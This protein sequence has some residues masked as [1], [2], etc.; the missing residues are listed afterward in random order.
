[1]SSPVASSSTLEGSGTGLV[2]PPPPPVP[3]LLGATFDGGCIV[4][5]HCEAGDWLTH[6][7]ESGGIDGQVIVGQYIC[8][9]ASCGKILL[10]ERDHLARGPT[11]RQGRAGVGKR[12]PEDKQR[13]S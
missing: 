2:P 12:E 4:E 7:N 10:R 5:R 13:H 11:I 6:D 8:P 1:M 9:T 3:L